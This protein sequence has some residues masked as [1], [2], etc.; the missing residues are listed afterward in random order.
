M[1]FPDVSGLLFGGIAICGLCDMRIG[2]AE[3]EVISESHKCLHLI[4][5]DGSLFDFFSSEL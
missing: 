4:S 1:L 2:E 3:D 5:E